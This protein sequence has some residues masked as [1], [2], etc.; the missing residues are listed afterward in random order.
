MS[1]SESESFISSPPTHPV[2]VPSL[3]LRDA[4]PWRL[5]FIRGL[6]AVLRESRPH[7]PRALLLLNIFCQV[8]IA[9]LSVT[10]TVASAGTVG[11]IID[12]DFMRATSGII[13]SM[14]ALLCLS[15]ATTAAGAT[16]EYLRLSLRAALTL[17]GLFGC[18][19]L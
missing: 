17:R 15:L 5:P 6:L 3:L 13:G 4:R 12:G 8:A 11:A 7:L 10:A 19:L 14:S 18:I 9:S 2:V 16:G 1:S